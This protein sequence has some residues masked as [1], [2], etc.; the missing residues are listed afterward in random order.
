MV[1]K[2]PAEPAAE[3]INASNDDEDEDD[4]EGEG[5]ADEDDDADDSWLVDDDGDGGEASQGKSIAY[6]SHMTTVS[7]Q[8]GHRACCPS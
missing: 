3:S 6:L 2:P 7:I 4:E 5:D 8:D 1:S